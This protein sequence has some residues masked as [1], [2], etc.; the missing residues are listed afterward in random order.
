MKPPRETTR[1]WRGRATL[2]PSNDSD[3]LDG[4]EPAGLD[5]PEERLVVAVVLI[6]VA[7]RERAHR[8]IERVRLP[9]VGADGDGVAGPCVSPGQRPSTQVRVERQPAGEHRL[10]VHGALHVAELAPVEVAVLIQALR[11]PQV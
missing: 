11:P 5:R 10:D 8:P 9:E 3:S 2:G 4:R 7:L 1:W 6:G